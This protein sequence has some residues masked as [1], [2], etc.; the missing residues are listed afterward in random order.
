MW[1]Q[2]DRFARC[3]LAGLVWA[4]GLTLA[5]AQTQA[6]APAGD[7][8]EMYTQAQRWLDQAL[9]QPQGGMPLRLEVLL[10]QLDRRLSL[11]PCQQVEPYLPPNTRLWGKS[12]LGLRCL[13]GAVKWNVFLPVTVRAWGPAW[14]IKGQVT[15]GTSLVAGDA[16]MVEVDWAEYNSPIVANAADWVGKSATRL[17]STGQALRQDMLKAAQVFQTGAQ[18]RVV[19]SGQGFE[20][21]ARAQALSAGVVGQPAMVR[22][23]NGQVVSGTVS[24]DRTVRVLL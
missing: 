9:A 17:L 15:P 19:A 1:I 16:M 18:V 8:P 22:M 10:G 2:S 14:V 11:A 12:R 3:L 23:D 6:P 5:H 24:E 21:S 13:Q 20:I 4:F 7:N